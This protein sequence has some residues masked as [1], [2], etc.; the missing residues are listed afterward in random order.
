MTATPPLGRSRRR[1]LI[2]AVLVAAVAG[3]TSFAT[4][5]AWFTA[6]KTAA[7]SSVTAGKLAFGEIGTTADQT[8]VNVANIYPMTDEQ[9][10]TEGRSQ[11]ITV[12][13]AGTL[14]MKWTINLVNPK[15]TAPMTAADLSLV[16]FKLY[17]DDNVM[18][19]ISRT[20]SFGGQPATASSDDY[21][22][23]G[24]ELAPGAERRLVM[25]TWLD[26]TAPNRLQETTASIDIVLNAIQTNAPGPSMI[27]ID[28]D[29]VY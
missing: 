28:M 4:S 27:S 14:P 24:G 6:T 21:I 2:A 8:T 3:G 1:L 12:R 23:W 13:N 26:A 11:V 29:P 20:R 17:S 25:R 18:S 19:P 15:A 5:G 22:Y 10:R 7:G 9:G 16:K